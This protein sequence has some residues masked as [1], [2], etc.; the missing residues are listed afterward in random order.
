MNH[1]VDPGVFIIGDLKGLLAMPETGSSASQ[2]VRLRLPANHVLAWARLWV[3][4]SHDNP[5]SNSLWPFFSGILK[6]QRMYHLNS[7]LAKLDWNRCL[8]CH[9][10]LYGY[11]RKPQVAA[12]L[13]NALGSHDGMLTIGA[14]SQVTAVVH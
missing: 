1:C 2:P 6:R 9:H 5:A 4:D 7:G 8:S 14:A 13:D 3:V 12:A 10:F 11:E